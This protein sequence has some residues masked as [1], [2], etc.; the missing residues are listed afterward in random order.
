MK[1]VLASVGSAGDVHPY[2]AIGHALRARGHEV[3][4]FCNTEHQV[5]IE[6]A[7]LEFLP[8]GDGLRYNE[9]LSNPDLWHPVKGMGVL[10]RT[11]LAPSM[12]PLYKVLASLY[13]ADSTLHG[14]GSTLRGSGS[15]LRV[16]AG[17]QMLGAR[18]AQVHLGLHLTS[19][20]TSP[21]A[22]RSAQAPITI[23]HTHWPVGTPSWLLRW[24]WSMVDRYKLEPMARPGLQRL[25]AQLGIAEPAIDQSLFGQWMHS[26][27]RAITLYPEWFAPRKPDLPKQLVYGSFAQYNL[28][29]QSDLPAD[30]Q[31]FLN[32]KNAGSVASVGSADSAP[33][34]IM[35]GTA[36]AH[37]G[38]Q[39][40]IWQEALAQL[41]MRGIFL[42]Q[43]TA[44]LPV[45]R[46]A[47]ILYASYAPFSALLP[48]CAALVHHGGIGSCAQALTAGI[49]QIIQP[50]AHDQ[51]ENARCVQALGAGLR[52]NRDAA[53]AATK[54]ALMQALQPANVQAAKRLSQRFD[55]DSLTQ[56]C[57]ELES[58]S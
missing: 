52:L 30:M 10:W 37:A 3:A 54:A 16:L 19:L 28:D 55:T 31:D 24:V 8:A 15:T 12:E 49:P 39:F 47:H 46:A 40:A 58:V 41:G 5:A 20:Y 51:F 2:L 43:H 32:T 11:L 25:C 38:K 45:Q 29:K 50:C 33:V 26:P 21:A 23:A 48:R 17:P 6:A 57:I 9:A 18:L 36:M 14:S 13:R 7:G 44:Q 42:S 22:L 35:F 27:E 34:A 1:F 4:F 56:L 53:V